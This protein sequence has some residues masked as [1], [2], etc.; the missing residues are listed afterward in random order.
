MKPKG[1]LIERYNLEVI[2][3][4]KH[5]ISAA[6]FNT[7]EILKA[8]V[9]P[10]TLWFIQHVFSKNAAESDIEEGEIFSDDEYGH[11]EGENEK[12][13][14]DCKENPNTHHTEISHVMAEE[15]KFTI[16]WQLIAQKLRFCRLVLRTKSLKKLLRCI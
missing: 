11:R 10:K 2:E 7:S 9:K 14:F 5:M 12:A 13:N 3:E 16:R 8:N 15:V 4:K 1:H 6:I